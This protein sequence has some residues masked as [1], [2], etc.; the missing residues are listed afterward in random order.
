MLG[1]F[2]GARHPPPTG[3]LFVLGIPFLQKYYT[4]YDQGNSRVGFAVANHKG[5]TPEV[6]ATINAT[7]TDMGSSFLARTRGA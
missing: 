4:V 6:L 7:R 2:H 3:P 1:R 5:R